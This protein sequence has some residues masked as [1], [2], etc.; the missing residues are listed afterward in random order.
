VARLLLDDHEH[1]RQR[2]Q[3]LRDLASQMSSD[4]A[5]EQLFRM[6]DDYERLARVAAQRCKNANGG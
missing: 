1:C 2:A 5:K 3:E 6:A 4:A